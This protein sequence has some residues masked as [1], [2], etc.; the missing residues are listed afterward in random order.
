MSH[1]NPA[2]Q[3]L[4]DLLK[5]VK[6]REG[7]EGHRSILRE[8]YRAGHISLQDL[9]FETL[10]P[11]P[12]LSKVVNF[13]IEKDLLGRIPEGILFTEQGMQF[14]EQT[15]G[16]QGFG[17]SDCDHCE[18]LPL[19]I[20]PRWEPVL[21]HLSPIFDKRPTVDTT[22]DQ[23]FADPETALL[24]A[25]YLYKNG[26]LE[27][28]SVVLLGDDDFTSVAISFLYLGI[29]PTTP[30]FIPHSLTVF[31]ID[32]RLLDAISAI[33]TIQQFPVTT[34]QWD[35][36]QPISPSVLHQFDTLVV[37]PPYSINGL[38]LV[39][40]RAIGLLREEPGAEVYLSYA[41]R[42]AQELHE[43]QTLILSLGFSILE[44]IPR[45]NY[46]EGGQILGNT[47]QMF[48][49]ATTSKMHTSILP[50]SPFQDLMYT[51]EL[52]PHIKIY[53]CTN[54]QR[55]ISLGKQEEFQTIEQLKAKGCPFCQSLGPFELDEKLDDE[56]EESAENLVDLFNAE[57]SEEFEN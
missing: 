52:N 25:M 50:E 18:G 24:R 45:F 46:Y 21:D 27:G 15:L 38:K 9:A 56:I 43:I 2:T 16:F 51:G 5:H 36:R 41:H 35:Y 20:S 3:F 54:C 13:L 53:F 23:A 48:R 32:Q 34:H 10:I 39:L 40:S 44:I 49:L 14:V 29:V 57:D 28:K 19:F 12:V 8:I 30:F 33:K 47:T 1:D 7:I 26:A 4:L 17:I 22:L 42:S 6:L 55:M 37:D 31:D 11:I